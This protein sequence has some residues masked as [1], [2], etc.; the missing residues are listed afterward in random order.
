M[1]PVVET[2]PPFGPVNVPELVNQRGAVRVTVPEWLTLWPSGPVTVTSRVQLPSEQL[3]LPER[4]AVLPFGPA[5]LREDEIWP[6]AVRVMLR[7]PVA[8]LPSGPV[9]V[10]TPEQLPAAQLP[11]REPVNPPLQAPTAPWVSQALAPGIV[12]SVIPTSPGTRMPNL[13]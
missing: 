5:M 13:I 8:V 4:E 3:V 12:R 10:R 9:T 7:V 6:G 11:E 1:T 2:V